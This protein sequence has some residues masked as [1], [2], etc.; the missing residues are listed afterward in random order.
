MVPAVLALFKVLTMLL[1]HQAT[2]IHYIKPPPESAACGIS[3]PHH[4]SKPAEPTTLTHTRT[5]ICTSCTHIHT[6]TFA[7]TVIICAA[8]SWLPS[9]SHL[10]ELHS[11]ASA[12]SISQH[13]AISQLDVLA[14]ELIMIHIDVDDKYSKSFIFI[15][16]VSSCYTT[17]GPIFR[18]QSASLANV[19]LW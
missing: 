1:V 6:P 11:H 4:W 9:V 3:K 12:Y 15:F 2:Y 5:H 16:I 7:H 10:I 17:G 8:T 14:W 18:L 19:L 13:S